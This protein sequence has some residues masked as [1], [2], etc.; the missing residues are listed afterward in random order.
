MCVEVVT[1]RCTRVVFWGCVLAVQA[2]LLFCSGGC[3][4]GEMPIFGGKKA[5][6]RVGMSK[7]E[8]REVLD[9]FGE[10]AAATIRQASGELDERIAT[11]RVRKTNLLWRI[12]SLQAYHAMMEVGDPVEAFVETWGLCVRIAEYLSS[13]E[14]S[15]LYGEHQQIAVG[16]ARQNEAEIERIGRMFLGDDVFAETRNQVHEFARTHP[17]RGTYSKLVV[18]ATEAR[19]DE[20]NAFGKI[21]SVPMAPFR[22]VGGV[23]RGAA[24][25]ERFTDTADRF[26][27]VV[28]ELPESARWQSL[29]LLYDMEETDVVQTMMANMTKVS[30]SSAK[31]ADAAQKLPE[32]LREEASVLIEQIDDKQA[33]L[34]VT[35]DKADKSA[36]S[37]ERTAAKFDDVAKSIEQTVKGIND[38]A[39][40]WEG[41]AKATTDTLKELNNSSLGKSDGEE[42]TFK[43]EDYKATAEAVTLTANELRA[44][45]VELRELAKAEE[46]P[47]YAS[48][49]QG[50][51]DGVT[52]RLGGLLLAGFVLA[53]LYRLISGRVARRSRQD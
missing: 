40:T 29:L 11:S 28:E 47:E 36:V 4:D 22:A 15:T 46:L 19:K 30:E 1:R 31:L 51:V 6:G 9:G 16:A 26:S 33:N 37:M 27:D 3:A 41:A 7:R 13:G 24:A 38:M 2:G 20:S 44:L 42:S 43:I 10:S 35:L 52:W 5:V 18:Y 32:Q 12:R 34:Q 48:A 23:D 21:L 14:G 49:A 45:V 17:I 25:I 8:L 39:D 53:V 50:L